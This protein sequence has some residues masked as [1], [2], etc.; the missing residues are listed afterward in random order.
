MRILIQDNTCWLQWRT[1]CL[2]LLICTELHMDS[3]EMNLFYNFLNSCIYSTIILDDH[4]EVWI[5]LFQL[6]EQLDKRKGVDWIDC[7][8]SVEE[9]RQMSRP[10][11]SAWL[12]S[13]TFPVHHFKECLKV[14]IETPR[15]SLHYDQQIHYHLH[16]LEGVGISIVLNP[17]VY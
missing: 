11:V 17:S 2:A 13:F 15:E 9:N 8:R 1:K 5:C 6:I 4:E 7:M 14:C 3:Q 10:S 12:K 16:I